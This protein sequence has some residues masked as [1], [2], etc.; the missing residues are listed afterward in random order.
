MNKLQI[1]LIVLMVA[2]IIGLTCGI[3]VLYLRTKRLSSNK[4]KLHFDIKALKQQ[5]AKS[6]ATIK[7]KHTAS[8]QAATKRIAEGEATRKDIQKAA[9]QAKK[10]HDALVARMRDNHKDTLSKTSKRLAS[11]C[12][13]SIERLKADHASDI[14]SVNA[15]KENVE[16]QLRSEMAIA[17]SVCDE[18]RAQAEY[19]ADLCTSDRLA[20]AETIEMLEQQVEEYA[21]MMEQ[22][23][24]QYTESMEAVQRQ[25]EDM[26]MM[27]DLV[28]STVTGFLR[29]MS[30]KLDNVCYEKNGPKKT[31]RLQYLLDTMKSASVK[32]LME[33]TP[34]PTQGTMTMADGSR[35]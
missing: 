24:Q 14:A 18:A 7:A 11:E 23:S 22:L 15:D 32:G 31:S 6:I 1:S 26:M 20:S 19:D 9:A 28:D 3:V 2:A 29:E 13:A 30:Q 5:H 27:F 8:M 10:S 16:M 25:S 12:D 33:M 34:G 17:E 35:L 4:S 21:G